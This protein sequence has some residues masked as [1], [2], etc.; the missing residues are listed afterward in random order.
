M[1]YPYSKRFLEI[2]E[3]NK[4]KIANVLPE[5][6]IHHIGSTAIPGIGGKG[7]IDILVALK[8]WDQKTKAIA[9]LRKLGFI[10]ANHEKKGRIFLAAT[11]ESGYQDVHLHLVLKNSKEYKEKLFFKEFLINNKSVANEYDQL[12]KQCAREAKGNRQQYKK[13]KASFIRNILNHLEQ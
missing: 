3:G 2:F 10:Y 11:Q 5:A 12:K 7:I 4:R 9:R 8:S 13:L 1:F 6:E